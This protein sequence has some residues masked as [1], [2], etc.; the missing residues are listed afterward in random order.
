MG[1]QF[2]ADPLSVEFG[3]SLQK[4][5]QDLGNDPATGKP[6]FKKHLVKDLTSVILPGIFENVRYVP[7]PRIEYSDPKIDAIVENLVI[8]SDNLMPNTLEIANDSYYRFG[9]KSVT[10][11][12]KQQFM[13]SV[14]GI[15]CDLKD[16]SYYVH[17]KQGF[18]SIKDTGIMDV[19]L[20]GEGFSF[21]LKVSS[22]DQDS[23]TERHHFFK[24]DKID[25]NIKKMKLKLKKS[26]HKTLFGL[27]KPVLMLVM[28]PAIQK[29]LEKQIKDT[30]DEMD[31]KFYAIQKE[32]EKAEE[33]FKRNPDPENAKNIYSRYY[34]AAQ[35]E[36]T[37][38][39]EKAEEFAKDKKANLAMTKEDSI[40]KDVALPGGVSTKA[41]EYKKMAREGDNWESPVFAIG[42]AKESTNIPAP[43]KVTR[44]PHN[45]KRASLRDSVPNGHHIPD[46]YDEIAAGRHPGTATYDIA[47]GRYSGNTY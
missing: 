35:K 15:Q 33:D 28:R 9:R 26:N 46:S 43:V 22:A 36:F 5:F 16:V 2:A 18:P 32:A 8:E 25:V 41:T 12:N 17:K 14:S 23:K 13:I 30:F 6:T 20:G 47:A 31:S 3:N 7:V 40:F 27:F 19:F 45:V 1:D 39:K 38:K 29:V 10:N 21:K 44:K 24:V 4:L 42:S 11:K 34:T 37:L